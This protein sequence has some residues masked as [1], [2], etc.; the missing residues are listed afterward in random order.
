MNTAPVQDLNSKNGNGISGDGD[1]SSIRY[2]VPSA[3]KFTPTSRKTRDM[4]S[5]L[6]SALKEMRTPSKKQGSRARDR[7]EICSVD[8]PVRIHN[9]K[10]LKAAQHNDTIKIYCSP[11][12]CSPGEK[13]PEAAARLV[14]RYLLLNSWRKS[15][16][17]RNELS[18]LLEAKEYKM[19]QLNIQIDVLQN[20]RKSESSR[21][22]EIAN[23]YQEIQ[24]DFDDIIQQNVALRN[25][26]ECLE[27]D[28]FGLV[29]EL[30]RVN[31]KTKYQLQEIE[32][33][34]NILNTLAQSQR[35]DKDKLR[36]INNQRL[37]LQEQNNKLENV[38][39]IQKENLGNLKSCVDAM[40]KSEYDLKCELEKSKK[41]C[42]HHL[43]QIRVL[44]L[45]KAK[46]KSLISKYEF[47]KDEMSREL[48][49]LQKELELSQKNCDELTLMNET[50]QSEMLQ[51]S[52][53]FEEERRFLRNWMKKGATSTYSLLKYFAEKILPALQVNFAY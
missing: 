24:K 19:S 40:Q 23:K 37:S 45:E 21:R 14:L 28:K 51:V 52:M 12:E 31:E 17:R 16:S 20:L 36:K 34:T 2:P 1:A 42:E 22:E 33:K 4:K 53:K 44:N 25:Y 35:R 29:S 6:E 27:K 10:G 47:E 41:T 38:I 50:I 18:S 26:I 43:E 30:Q 9:R 5:K 7:S 3:R 15:R 11:R 49:L 48:C 8:S 46:N 13:F 39:S 32:E